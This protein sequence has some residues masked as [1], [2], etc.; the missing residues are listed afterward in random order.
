[1]AQLLMPDEVKLSGNHAIGVTPRERRFVC[2]SSWR[3]Q[4][5]IPVSWGELFL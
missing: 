4:G 1:M 3:Q 2:D 5:G